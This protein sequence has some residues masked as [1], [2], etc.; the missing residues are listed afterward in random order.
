[1]RQGCILS[2]MLFSQALDWHKVTEG[3]IQWIQWAL[4]I[5]LDD[6]NIGQMTER[7]SKT[8]STVGQCKQDMG[9]EEGPHDSK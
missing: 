2:P 4:T 5:V 6:Q 3:R 1:M 7:N 9:H 8:A